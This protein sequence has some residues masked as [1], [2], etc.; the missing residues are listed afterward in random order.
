MIA[1]QN[2]ADI[3]RIEYEQGIEKLNLTIDLFD[4]SYRPILNRV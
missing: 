1:L 4:S 2:K 3:A